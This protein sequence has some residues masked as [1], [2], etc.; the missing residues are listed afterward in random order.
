MVVVLV[1]LL[2]IFPLVVL[3]A[4]RMLLAA[5]AMIEGGY[6]QGLLRGM[7]G[8][9]IDEKCRYENLLVSKILT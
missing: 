7:Y 3:T 4:E 2:F 6:W 1:E 5:A 9:P 8:I